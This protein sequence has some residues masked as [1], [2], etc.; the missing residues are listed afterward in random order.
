MA[1]TD[2]RGS[3]R[4]EE[5]FKV[6]LSPLAMPCGHLRVEL[7]VRPLSRTIRSVARLKPHENSPPIACTRNL[8]NFSPSHKAIP[9]IPKCVYLTTHLVITMIVAVV[10]KATRREPM[11]T[12]FEKSSQS[13][14]LRLK[15]LT[16]RELELV[17]GGCGDA[18]TTTPC[19]SNATNACT[20]AN[21]C[22][23][24]YDCTSC[25]T[26]PF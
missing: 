7:G 15:K 6:S 21:P 17:S 13:R 4:A 9:W 8:H 26:C 20:E 16:L 1:V 14:K 11:K 19:S 22:D 24:S 10:V 2:E 23:T 3:T 25:D 12:D 18:S 5:R